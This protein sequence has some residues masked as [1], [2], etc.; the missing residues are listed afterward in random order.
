MLLKLRV[1]KIT[2]DCE[3]RFM[4]NLYVAGIMAQ[5]QPMVCRCP[6]AHHPLAV[7]RTCDVCFHRN[8]RVPL[9]SEF[10]RHDAAFALYRRHS[11]FSAGA[12]APQHADESTLH[13]HGHPFARDDQ[14]DPDSTINTSA[15]DAIVNR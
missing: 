11:I 10:R 12:T 9:P 3:E 14:F 13:L 7:L 1:F 5:I 2:I 4:L 8:E 6:N 15:N